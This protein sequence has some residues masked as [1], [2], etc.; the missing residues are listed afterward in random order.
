[1]KQLQPFIEQFRGL[2]MLGNGRVGMETLNAQSALERATLV[3]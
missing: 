1:M 2:D 3:P